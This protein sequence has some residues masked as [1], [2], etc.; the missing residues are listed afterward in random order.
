M[1]KNV[2]LLGF[3]PAKSDT[4]VVLL[5]RQPCAAIQNSKDV[6]WD[7]SQWAPLIEDRSFLSWLVKIP[8]ETEQLRARQITFGQINKLEEMWKDNATA[9]L[10]D[11]NK[12]EED[13]EAPEVPLR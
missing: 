3:I 10:E 12:A 9:T 13:D 11:L 6:V 2:F 1:P 4:V 7:T 8:T 5:C